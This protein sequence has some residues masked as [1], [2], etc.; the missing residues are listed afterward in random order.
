MEILVD[1]SYF[2]RFSAAVKPPV[3]K[4]SS[5]GR[6]DRLITPKGGGVR[7]ADTLAHHRAVTAEAA[8]VLG[9]DVARRYR[10]D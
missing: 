3:R 9:V 10:T 2:Y 4:S 6:L 7:G 1:G 5:Q 8:A